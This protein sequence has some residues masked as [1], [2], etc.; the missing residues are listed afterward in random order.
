M[1]AIQVTTCETQILNLMSEIIVGV[2]LSD[3]FAEVDCAEESCRSSEGTS[4]VHP[5]WLR[6]W[7]QLHSLLKW[8]GFGCPIVVCKNNGSSCVYGN[9]FYVSISICTFIGPIWSLIIWVIYTLRLVPIWKQTMVQLLPN[10][11][12]CADNKHGKI[13]PNAEHEH[14]I[15]KSH[16]FPNAEYESLLAKSCWF[17]MR[18]CETW[19]HTNQWI[20]AKAIWYS[21]MIPTGN[22]MCSTKSD[23]GV[24]RCQ[25]CHCAHLIIHSMS[26]T[27]NICRLWFKTTAQ[28]GSGVAAAL[29]AE[30]LLDPHGNFSSIA[31]SPF[32][33]PPPPL[34]FGHL[35]SLCFGC[36]QLPSTWNLAHPFHIACCWLMPIIT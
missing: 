22:H 9:H 24:C 30:W 31:N 11:H 17:N 23:L 36:T 32:D 25:K 6:Q 5:E 2:M 13:F 26:L 28:G 29:H 15:G 7:E 1:D 27:W 19:G 10:G 35:P 4:T 20:T 34:Q 8:V 14:L 18:Y 12:K 16:C 33:S 21:T 3:A